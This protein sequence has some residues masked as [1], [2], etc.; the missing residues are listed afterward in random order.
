VDLTQALSEFHPVSNKQRHNDIWYD[1]KSWPAHSKR[2]RAPLTAPQQR[3]NL[4][5]EGAAG[6]SSQPPPA[7]Q[8]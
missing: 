2:I 1:K 5:K 7:A 3:T 8:G 4:A 6:A